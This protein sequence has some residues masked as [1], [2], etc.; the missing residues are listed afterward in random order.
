M[1]EMNYCFRRIKQSDIDSI[2]SL[3]ETLKDENVDMSFAEII[4]KDEVL[5]FIDNPAELTYVAVTEE[6][7]N[8]A[9]C[10]VKGRRDLAKEKNILYFYQQPLIQM[11]VVLV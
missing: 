5:S 2:W 8:R 7:P 10:L 11:L 1:V 9:L 3:I 6:E 4:D